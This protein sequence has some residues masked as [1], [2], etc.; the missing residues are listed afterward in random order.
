MQALSLTTRLAF[1]FCL[2]A[3][4]VFGSAGTHRYRALA[5]QVICRD[6]AELL[7]K[8]ARVRNERMAQGALDSAFGL[9]AIRSWTT[10]EGFARLSQLSADLAHDFRTPICGLPTARTQVLLPHAQEHP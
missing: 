7:R 5:T 3:A 1:A 2:I 6:D 10:R 4:T 9:K 8:A